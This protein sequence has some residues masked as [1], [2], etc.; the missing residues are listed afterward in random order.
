MSI[1]LRVDVDKPYGNAN[2]FRKVISKVMEDYIGTAFTHSPA[3]LSHQVQFLEFCNQNKVPGYFYYRTCTRPNEKVLELMDAGGHKTG[4]HAENTRTLE[5][6][7]AELTAFRNKLPGVEV[8]TFSK[9][10]SGVLKLGKHH[11]P[12]CEPEKYLEWAK[13]VKCIYPSGND[14][15]ETAEDLYAD[16]NGFHKRI[17]WV[18]PDY[19]VPGFNTVEQLV[20]AAKKERV[21]ILVHPENYITHKQVADEFKLLVK[22]AKEEQVAWEMP[23]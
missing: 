12:P 22:R 18:E 11:Y 19:R 7:E 15:C 8:G 3:Y 9:H 14:I 6:F 16:E 23:F 2:I 13:Q 4:F 5:T 20:Q 21:V 17:F 1:V 10:G